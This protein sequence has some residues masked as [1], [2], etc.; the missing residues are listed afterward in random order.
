MP[1]DVEKIKF[2]LD[3]HDPNRRT[4]VVGGGTITLALAHKGIEPDQI[5]TLLDVDVLCSEEY[6]RSLSS[7]PD[8][9]TGIERFKIRWPKDRLLERGSTTLA[10][11]LDPN[12]SARAKGAVSF[13]A[14]VAMSDRY[15]SMSYEKCQETFET[16]YCG[17]RSI[18][19][20]EMLR[21]LSI[22]GRE[23]DLETV[24][25]I[26]P[27]ASQA[28]LLSSADMSTIEAEYIKSVSTRLETPESY[29]SRST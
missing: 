18:R 14:C 22:I 6:F 9:L 17:E 26:L 2:T 21:W 3:K 12:A 23:K 13:T 10:L 28:G 4:I 15:Y 29:Y 16:E 25:K 5:K 11:D 8:L 24:K 27:I 7:R 20:S 1:S 19:I